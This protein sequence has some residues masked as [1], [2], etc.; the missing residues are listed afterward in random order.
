MLAR[1]DV[2]DC[3]SPLIRLADVPKL[4]WLPTRGGK[5]LHVATVY[6]W[7]TRGIGR[8]KLQAVRVGGGLATRED[9]L[10]TFFNQLGPNG[11]AVTVRTPRQRERAIE[12]ADRELEE[13]RI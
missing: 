2:Q 8:H 4:K 5:R 3:E 1:M 13:A 9:W 6:R 11:T 10:W 7:V 12:R